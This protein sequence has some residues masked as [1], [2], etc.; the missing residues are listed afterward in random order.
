MENKQK[1]TSLISINKLRDFKKEITDINNRL[2]IIVEK[3]G[4]TDGLDAGWFN[5]KFNIG[6][7]L[8][9]LNIQ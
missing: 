9:A 3:Y 7:Y 4:I 6:I 1:D 5:G 8:G 2:E